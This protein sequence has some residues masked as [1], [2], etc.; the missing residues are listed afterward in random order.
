[1]SDSVVSGFCTLESSDSTFRNRQFARGRA[2]LHHT[3]AEGILQQFTK[4]DSRLVQLGL[5]ISGRAS[6]NFSNLMVFV[7]FDIVEKEHFLV[8]VRQLL[9]GA[10][11]MHAV[12][13]SVE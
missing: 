12:D 9:D 7:S 2:F 8:S 6:Q 3:S 5:G 4:P 10:V 13:Y 11:Q 1:M